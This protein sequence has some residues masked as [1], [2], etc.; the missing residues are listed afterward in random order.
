MKVIK[1]IP[2]F[3]TAWLFFGPV[4]GQTSHN[5]PNILVIVADDLGVRDVSCQGGKDVQTPA[6]DALATD[7]I[8]FANFYANSSVCSPTRAALLSGRYPSYVGVPGV[9]RTHAENNWGYLAPNAV[10]LPRLLKTQGYHTSLIGKWHLGLEKPNIPNDHG[11]DE[12]HGWLGDMMDDYVVKRRH[13]IN[14][15]RLNGDSIDPVGHATD[16]FT[17]WAVDYVHNRAAKEEPFFLY[18]AYNAPHNPVQPPPE[19]LQRVKHRQPELDEDRARLVALIEHLDQ[20]IGQVVKALKETGLYD[21][22]LILFTSDNGGQL[23]DG[24]INAPYRAGKGT[25]YEGGLRV[26]ALVVWKGHILPASQTDYR[27]IS[28]DVYPTLAEVAGAPV[29]HPIEGKSFLPTLLGREQSDRDRALFF[30]RRE[31]GEQFGGLTIQAVLQ[32]EWKLLQ[33]SPYGAVEL[34]NIREDPY[35]RN[36]LATAQPERGRELGRLLRQ[37]I[38]QGGQIP[39]QPPVEHL[40]LIHNN[41]N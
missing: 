18:L 30:E 6:I 24:A 37:H 4:T 31:G 28:M 9:V 29:L 8:R 39:W 22:T 36:N 17:R 7:G 19:W 12:F 27:A 23:G 15:M 1:L 33:N 2:L 32:N 25:M 38:Q 21:N 26:P 34:Y 11:F 14:Y 10:L 35:E 40:T 20:G 13:G 16:L 5:P 3:L 41:D